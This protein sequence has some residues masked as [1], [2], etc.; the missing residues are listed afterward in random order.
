MKALSFSAKQILPALLDRTKTQ[1]IR[2]AWK[3]LDC[4]TYHDFKTKSND[5]QC[6]GYGSP[7]IT[8][9]ES[10]AGGRTKGFLEKPTRFSIGEKVRLFWKMR[11]T[12][13]DARFCRNHGKVLREGAVNNKYLCSYGPGLFHW[14][15]FR[16]TF[17]KVLGVVEITD[18]FK[19]QME[20]DLRSYSTRTLNCNCKK[21]WQMGNRIISDEEYCDGTHCE[22]LWQPDGF[23]TEEDFVLYFLEN[24][25]FSTP[26][27]FW[28][29]RWR[30][31]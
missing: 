2:K 8:Y 27:P 19:I 15:G 13:K 30:W 5:L 17:P 4:K 1:S 3:E 21:P 6:K 26:K 29:Y 18:V 11:G 24:Y 14:I 16:N 22:M 9:T 31:L 25:D 23:K 7:E 10:I 12:P 28:V 20:G